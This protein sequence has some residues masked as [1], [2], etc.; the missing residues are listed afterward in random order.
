MSIHFY[1]AKDLDY[2]GMLE[3]F[4]NAEEYAACVQR[5][6]EDDECIAKCQADAHNPAKVVAKMVMAPK[7]DPLA[8]IV[9]TEAFRRPLS[10]TEMQTKGLVP[11]AE[12]QA[13][14][15][16]IKDLNV[17]DVTVEDLLSPHSRLDGKT[18]CEAVGKLTDQALTAITYA[19]NGQSNPRF[20]LNEC[21]DIHARVKLGQ[22]AADNAEDIINLLDDDAYES[23]CSTRV[24]EGER[25]KCEVVAPWMKAD[26]QEKPVSV[27]AL[28]EG[29]FWST[30]CG[31][32]TA[33]RDRIKAGIRKRVNAC[34][35][36]MGCVYNDKKFMRRHTR[37]NFPQG[38]TPTNICCKRSLKAAAKAAL[39]MDRVYKMTRNLSLAEQLDL[40]KNSSMAE[41]Q[42]LQ[43]IQ[44][45][46]D[47]HQEGEQLVAD[48]EVDRP[49]QTFIETFATMVRTS[50]GEVLEQFMQ[51]GTIEPTTNADA[52]K[53]LMEITGSSDRASRILAFLKQAASGVAS[54]VIEASRLLLKAVKVFAKVGFNLIKY[55]LHHPTTVM[56]IA[57]SAKIFKK[58]L[59][60][61][62]SLK[63]F[64]DPQMVEV[65][66]WQ[67]STD[68]YE[69]GVESAARSYAFIKKSFLSIAYQIIDGGSFAAYVQRFTALIQK[70]LMFCI[71][72][73]PVYGPIIVA[74]IQATGAFTTIVSDSMKSA[75]LQ[76][77]KYALTTVMIKEAKTD[78]VDVLLGTCIAAP[79]PV[80]VLTQEGAKKEL[81]DAGNVVA[82]KLQGVLKRPAEFNPFLKQNRAAEVAASKDAEEEEGGFYSY[83]KALKMKL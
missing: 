49:T 6:D 16:D 17:V 73:I 58:E 41:E 65:G 18:V 57:Y 24:H 62:I 34:L 83:I 23:F 39:R 1:F 79:D 12:V 55:I 2:L 61:E 47:A 37:A 21:T 5:C 52:E 29:R 42:K 27:C 50:L 75:M 43:F 72:S 67:K 48:L 25:E 77:T 82:Q 15:K 81:V 40:V 7:G 32:N 26:D 63:I 53:K 19:V 33:Q 14:S 54:M 31:V 20:V 28:M 45:V 80:K 46:Q 3:D 51:L 13:G 56:W 38:S 4:K 71:A 59:C 70:G 9:F 74:S 44:S 35:A 78:V 11:V 30:K 76:A 22:I 10:P 66:L 64:G 60:K 8:G 36:E 69:Q 68:L